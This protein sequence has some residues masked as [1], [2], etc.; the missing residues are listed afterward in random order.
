M[1]W[2]ELKLPSYV[3]SVYYNVCNSRQPISEWNNKMRLIG[4]FV[5]LSLS[6]SLKNVFFIRVAYFNHAANLLK[7]FDKLLKINKYVNLNRL[8]D[9]INGSKLLSVG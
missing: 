2:G 3:Y 5:F 1:E 9:C 6:L 7:Y 8:T 4:Y